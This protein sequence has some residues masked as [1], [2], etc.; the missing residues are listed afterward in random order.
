LEQISASAEELSAAIQELSS[1]A[2]EVMAAVEQINKAAQIQSSATHETASALS[3]IDRS[4]RLSQANAKAGNERVANLEEALKEA[5]RSIEGLIE[6]V[7]SALGDTRASVSS[8][9]SLESVGRRIEKII[10][11]ITLVAIQTSMLA[12]SGSVEAARAGESGR[13]FAVVSNDIRSLARD[14]SANVERAK[15]T[16]RGILDQ[17]GALKSDLQQITATAQVEVQK[18]QIVSARLL[19]LADDVA[20]LGVASKSILGGADNVLLSTTEISQAAQQVASAAEEAST[21]SR[22][23]AAAASQQSRGAEDLAAA[24]EEIASLAEAMR[25]QTA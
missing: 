13:G 20:A 1:A 23:A 2:T 15:D 8:I 6:G 18:N 9:A 5:Q 21:A 24:I 12:V 14:A 11:T 16:V 4:A 25:Q 19:Q 17:I 3:Q 7:S 10:D 22:E